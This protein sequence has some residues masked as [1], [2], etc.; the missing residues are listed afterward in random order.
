MFG[1]VDRPRLDPDGCGVVF[2]MLS[3]LTE[4]GR[5]GMTAIGSSATD[6]QARFDIAQRVLLDAAATLGS[7]VA[8]VA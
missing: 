7:E 1:L 5:M 2:H 3:A 4:L 8:V 6:A